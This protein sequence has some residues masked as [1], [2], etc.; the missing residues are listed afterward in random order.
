MVHGPDVPVHGLLRTV[1]TD[2]SDGWFAWGGPES[3]VMAGMRGGAQPGTDLSTPVRVW[4]DGLR[5]RVEELDGAINVLANAEACW[6]WEQG[7]EHPFAAKRN[8]LRL[9]PGPVTLLERRPAAEFLG[10]DFTR[11]TGPVGATTYLYRPAWTVELAPPAHKPHPIQL[12]IDAVTGMVLQ[13]RHDATGYHKEWLE[14]T[15]GDTFPDSLFRWDGPTRGRPRWREDGDAR[16]EA[17]MASRREWFTANVAALPLAV[18]ISVDVLVHDRDDDGRFEASFDRGSLA[19][20]P[21]SDE[22]WDLGWQK[23]DHRW[24]TARWDWAVSTWEGPLTAHGLASLQ[25]QCRDSSGAGR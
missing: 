6:Q 19:R 25:E 18:E 4:R 2:D 24:S 21:R 11:P 8:N 3:P 14:L 20:R 23:V 7:I 17:E 12:V 1:G 15:L 9:M 13:Q 22:P 16:H 5:L 10:D